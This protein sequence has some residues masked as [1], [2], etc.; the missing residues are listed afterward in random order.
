ML[1]YD[2]LLLIA[3]AIGIDCRSITV[4]LSPLQAV[5]LELKQTLDRCTQTGGIFF[6]LIFFVGDF[7]LTSKCKSTSRGNVE[8]PLHTGAR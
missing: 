1:P 8:P 4:K 6:I 2:T 3:I 7:R 5:A